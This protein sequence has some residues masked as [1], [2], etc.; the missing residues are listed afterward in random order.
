MGTFE[1][2]IE[3]TVRWFF[4]IVIVAGIGLV[5]A[6]PIMWTWNY[7]MPFL[8]KLPTI[9]WGMAWCLNFLAGF[10]WKTILIEKG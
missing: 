9:T 10:I 7:V 2:F 3:G 6:F 8:F 1:K 4:A 5:L